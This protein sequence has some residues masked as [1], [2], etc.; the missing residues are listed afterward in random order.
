MPR[1]I[2][3]SFPHCH[4]LFLFIHQPNISDLILNFLL[5][6]PLTLGMKNWITRTICLWFN[7]GVLL[8]PLFV[9][10]VWVFPPVL[11][12]LHLSRNFMWVIFHYRLSFNVKFL[13]D[14]ILGF[15]NTRC[16]QVTKH[17]NKLLM[18]T[19]C[20]QVTKCIKLLDSWNGRSL[21]KGL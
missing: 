14:R 4:L 13:L 7:S 6:Y 11:V 1:W 21:G 12:S 16:W 5:G 20:W 19:R 8:Y 9:F 3:S 17:I 15:S 2:E 10:S 18:L